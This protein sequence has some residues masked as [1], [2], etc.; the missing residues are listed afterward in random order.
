MICVVLLHGQFLKG[1]VMPN[2]LVVIQEFFKILI[3]SFPF[4]FAHFPIFSHL[5]VNDIQ[6]YYDLIPSLHAACVI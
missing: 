4:I 5:D 3:Q 1:C 2:A 6:F